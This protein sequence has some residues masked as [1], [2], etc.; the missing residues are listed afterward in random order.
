MKT[1]EF[2]IAELEAVMDSSAVIDDELADTSRWY[3]IRDLVFEADGRLWRVQYNVGLTENQSC[4]PFEFQ[5]DPI[6]AEEVE[7]F[8]VSVTRYRPVR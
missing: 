5:H 3:E 7:P 2:T 4:D 8:E 1:R 6:K